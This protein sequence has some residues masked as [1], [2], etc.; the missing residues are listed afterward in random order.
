MGIRA[1]V[2]CL[3]LAQGFLMMLL[4]CGPTTTNVYNDLFKSLLTCVVCKLWQA[5]LHWFFFCTS[6]CSFFV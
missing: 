1:R 5:S 6:C 4:F 3:V 2:S